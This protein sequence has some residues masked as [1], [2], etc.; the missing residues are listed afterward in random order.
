MTIDFA[1]ALRSTRRDRHL[2]DAEEIFGTFPEATFAH[3]N[4]LIYRGAWS[5]SYG[6]YRANSVVHDDSGFSVAIRD[7]V[8]TSSNGPGDAANWRAISA[9]VAAASIMLSH[10]APEVAA[11]L[12]G[13]AGLASTQLDADTADKQA[14][15]RAAI[16]LVTTQG[17][18][19]ENNS[20]LPAWLRAATT[21]EQEAMRLRIRAA[22]QPLAIGALVG[23]ST[24]RV[25]PT[26]DDSENIVAYLG[27]DFAYRYGQAP[28]NSYRVIVLSDD[29]HLVSAIG[30]SGQTIDDWEREE[31]TAADNDTV[32]FTL[33]PLSGSGSGGG[34]DPETFLFRAERASG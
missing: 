5:D 32:V 24:T 12:L 29:F 11:R 2:V 19:I 18:T 31:H 3:I 4:F 28:R 22:E 13:A 25:A 34:R 23:N 1:N 30:E 26:G 21:E 20:I 8:A 7:H 15:F 27:E 17:H 10:L 16:G 6:T 33:G 9:E 14:A